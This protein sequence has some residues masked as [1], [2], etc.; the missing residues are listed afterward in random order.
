[1]LSCARRPDLLSYE[2]FVRARKPQ[3]YVL[4]ISAGAGS[5]VY[6]GVRHTTSPTD[7]QVALIQREW[8]AARPTRAFNEGGDP[9]VGS[10]LEAAV[11]LHGEP[12]LVRFL[13]ARDRIAVRSFEPPR[14]KE[15]EDLLKVFSVEQVRL[16]YV[17]RQIAQRRRDGTPT[18]SMMRQALRQQSRVKALAGHPETLE[19]LHAACR[20][21]LPPLSSCGELTDVWFDPTLSK[22]TGFTNEA[23]R[24]SG[25]LRDRYIIDV[26]VQA[27][28]AGERVFAVA[29]I[30]HVVMQEPVL[31]AR[32]RAR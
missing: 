23:S 8:I 16:F 25:V 32:L 7:S 26:L 17:G 4:R 13:A 20:R 18:D 28:S 27:V 9:P 14:D 31:R 6:V 22:P 29:G 3:P 1:M 15:V 10:S 24:R 12:G 30:G 11:S 19:E 2:E 21:L 5:L